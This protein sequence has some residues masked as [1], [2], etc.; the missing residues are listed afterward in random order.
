MVEE[1]KELIAVIGT[2][3]QLALWVA[4]GFWA[5]KV[6]IIGSIYGVIWLAINKAYAAFTRPKQEEVQITIDG[7]VYGESRARLIGILRSIGAGPYESTA[8]LDW[9]QE[10]VET[11]LEKDGQP[12]KSRPL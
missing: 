3:P 4:V 1:L 10:A 5:Y 7:I 6:I 2:L 12:K 9:L 11:K 8:F